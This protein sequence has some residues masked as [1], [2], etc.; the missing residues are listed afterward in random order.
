[1]QKP[2]LTITSVVLTAILTLAVSSPK[3]TYCVLSAPADWIEARKD[4]AREEARITSLKALQLRVDEGDVDAMYTFGTVT[5]GWP[6][7]LLDQFGVSAESGEALIRA[8]A[9]RGHVS[10]RVSVWI[11]DGGDSEEL[12]AIAETALDE[13]NDLRILGGLSGLL[14]WNAI[15]ECSASAR[16]MEG[17]VHEA[18]LPQFGNETA[19]GARISY[20]EFEASFSEACP[21]V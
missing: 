21:G 14:R 10:A 5:R 7:E 8:A 16:D 18:S 19:A 12:V 3:S 9:E 2:A 11:M 20:A 17:R 15:Q 4:A 6:Q 1:M 13:T